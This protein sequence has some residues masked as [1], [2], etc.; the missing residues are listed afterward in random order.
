MLP[1]IHGVQR[2]TGGALLYP[3]VVLL[4]LFLS[5]GD[6]LRFQ[7]PILLLAFSDALAAVVGLAYGRL[8]FRIFNDQ[9][10]VEGSRV[11]SPQHWR[12]FLVRY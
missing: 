6:P 10:S 7:I 1:S 5:A 3:F 12:L 9:R 11:C 4:V 2:P 8:H